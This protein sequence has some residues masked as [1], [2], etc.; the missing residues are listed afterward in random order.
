[1]PE[2][3][4]SVSEG[5]EVLKPLA[6]LVGEILVYALFVFAF[7][8]FLAR[9]DIITP[10]VNRHTT[11][12]YRFLSI[13]SY[14]VRHFLMFPVIA[15]FWFASIV[16]ILS[17]L[18]QNQTPENVLLVS[19]ALVSTIRAAAY[20][21]EDLSRDLAKMLP[22]AVLGLYLVDES[23]LSRSVSSGVL[24]DMPDHW[25]VAVYYIAFV[26]ILEFA[27]RLC[28]GLISEFKSAA[29]GSSLSASTTPKTRAPRTMVRPHHTASE[30]HG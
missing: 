27:L 12:G 2:A 8:R 30:Y 16:C 15:V 19:I 13:I 26:V 28:Y 9:R 6:V 25:R 17:L 24:E 3:E 21:K 22:F 29:A 14:L 18:A 23:Y 11:A 20:F 1:M 5:I 7:Y 10:R 4:F